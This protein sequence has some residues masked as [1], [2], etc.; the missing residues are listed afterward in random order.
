MIAF[1]DSPTVLQGYGPVTEWEPPAEL[2]CGNGTA[3]G[4]A[5]L[6]TLRL[7]K[8]HIDALSAQGISIQHCFCFLVT[9]GCPNSEP[10]ERFEEA[11]QLIEQT[12]KSHFSFYSIAV[13]GADIKMLRRLTPRRT[14][15][16]LAE[17][18]DFHRF[19]AWLGHSLVTVSGSQVGVQ[20]KLPNPVKTR[21]N[22]EGDP[23]NP[24]GWAVVP[25][26]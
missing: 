2:E 10:P 5:I 4:T 22:K 23:E 24:L 6:K 26:T 20:I 15:L 12:E 25:P 3:M 7:Q 9:D 11:A 21:P 16:K 18:K 17:V 13:K 1:A 8:E 14:P 19:L